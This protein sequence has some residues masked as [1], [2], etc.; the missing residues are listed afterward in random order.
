M[1]NW[2]AI[3]ATERG[4]VTASVLTAAEW[5]SDQ[6]GGGAD[7][8]NFKNIGAAGGYSTQAAAQKVVDAFNAQPNTNKLA[9]AG[10]TTAPNLPNPLTGVAAIGD[11]FSKLGQRNTWL[12]IGKVV[13]GLVLIIVGLVQLTHTQKLVKTAGEAA[14]LA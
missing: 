5:K 3:A 1:A 9:K 10:V 14:V 2:Y 6:A 8:P 4:V 11:F 7:A 12:R 13:V